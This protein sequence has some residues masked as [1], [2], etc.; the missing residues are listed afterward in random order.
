[1]FLC[2]MLALVLFKDKKAEETKESKVTESVEEQAVLKNHTPIPNSTKI[3]LAEES[4]EAA[5]KEE[6]TE[7]LPEITNT[8]V[9]IITPS[10][11]P[12]VVETETPKVVLTQTPTPV[13]TSVP[14]S[15]PTPVP[16][17][18]PTSAP[19]PVPTSVPTSAPT[20]V[21]T[22]VPTSA[23][24]PIPTPA[25]VVSSTPLPEVPEIKEE[26]VHEFKMSVW[27]LP[28]CQKSGYYNNVCES[29]G[30]VECITQEPIPHEVEDIIIQEGNCME[31]TVIRHI[32]KMC[33]QQVKSD[34][35]YTVYD[36]H[37]WVK[38]WVDGVEIEYCEWCGVAK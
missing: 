16:T 11:I 1:M 31:D 27:E 13:P 35:R 14:T 3:P 10:P 37:L 6:K 26:H 23:P 17:S 36:K 8:P 33:E 38:E 21:P 4:E 20:P 7:P 9:P 22:S 12:E 18:V 24:T 34:T 15:A 2:I 30:V 5:E 19:T 32:C 28:T 25:P 29:C